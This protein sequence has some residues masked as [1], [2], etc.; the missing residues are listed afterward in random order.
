MGGAAPENRCAWA[1]L[2]I[3]TSAEQDVLNIVDS[4]GRVGWIVELEIG[5]EALGF[6]CRRGCSKGVDITVVRGSPVEPVCMADGGDDALLVRHSVAKIKILMNG[7]PFKVR[8]QTE[9]STVHT[10]L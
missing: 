10:F 2:I 7:E 5:N 1:G 8:T 6:G 9:T 3:L 4:V